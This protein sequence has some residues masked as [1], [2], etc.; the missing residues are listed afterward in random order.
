[1]MH[2]LKSHQHLMLHFSHNLKTLTMEIC[3]VSTLVKWAFASTKIQLLRWIFEQ[4][5]QG[6]DATTQPVQKM[7]EKFVPEFC[8]KTMSAREQ[9]VRRFLHSARLT[10]THHFG[11]HI[12]QKSHKEMEGA[13]CDFMKLM[14]QKVANMNPDHVLNMD[15]APIHFSYHFK[16]TWN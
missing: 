1:M 3:I 7:A 15:Q 16:C 2:L 9:V 10:Y 8:A 6:L 5:K 13:A 12:A 11:T 14:R 4:C